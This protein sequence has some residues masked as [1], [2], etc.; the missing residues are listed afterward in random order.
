MQGD[1]PTEQELTDLIY[2]SLL[3]EATW[4]GFLDR[5][6]QLLPGG[7]STLFFHD[8]NRNVGRYSLVSR[9]EDADV[10]RYDDHF[11]K[12]NPWMAKAAVR[13]VDLGVVAE[14]M[15]PRTE[16]VRTEFYSDFLRPVGAES[17]VGVTVMRDSGC[18]FL[19]S[20]MTESAEPNANMAAAKT[21]GA[22]APHLRRAF[23]HYRR[24]AVARAQEGVVGSVLESLGI[25]VMIV[26]MGGFVRSVS[27]IAGNII[28]SDCGLR[29]SPVGRLRAADAQV[30][31][32]IDAMTDSSCA[33]PR[34]ADALTSGTAGSGATRVTLIRVDRDRFEAYFEGPLVIVL[35]ESAAPRA[36]GPAPQLL[37]GKYRLTAAE[38][39]VVNGLAAGLTVQQIADQSELSRETIRNQLKSVFSKVGVTRQVD[40][41]RLAAQLAPRTD[42]RRR[43]G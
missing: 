25:G 8:A 13:P 7:R 23:N 24:G 10:A 29:V 19:L 26:G 41:V 33:S 21:L 38:D 32:L 15:L 17:A 2:A 6:T 9:I 5:L 27:P 42:A 12:V 39:R 34:V 3:G 4:Q 30:S 11:S 43:S 22:L 37:A 1:E 35:L 36:T 31:L 16:L 28:E 20:V 14:L 40:L 18:S